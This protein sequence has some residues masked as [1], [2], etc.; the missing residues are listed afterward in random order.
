MYHLTILNIKRSSKYSKP[1]Q[2]DI[3]NSQSLNLQNAYISYA[4]L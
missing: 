1:K 4:K 2:K 3:V